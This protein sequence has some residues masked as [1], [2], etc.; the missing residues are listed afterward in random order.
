MNDETD[1][2]GPYLKRQGSLVT[3]KMA[4][5]W[6]EAATVPY[7]ERD[8]ARARLRG[9]LSFADDQVGALSLVDGTGAVSLGDDE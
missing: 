5:M 4:R 6:G 8:R 9:A 7:S 2:D 1:S 3:V